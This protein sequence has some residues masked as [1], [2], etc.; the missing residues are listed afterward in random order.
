[1]GL[2]L[3]TTFSRESYGGFWEVLGPDNH[4]FTL[5][6][7]RDNF[8]TSL[9]KTDGKEMSLLVSDIIPF[10]D[11]WRTN[12][13]LGTNNSTQ[14]EDINSSSLWIVFHYTQPK[15]VGT[16]GNL[17]FFTIPSL[18]NATDGYPLVTELWK[19][20]GTPEGTTM[21]Y[22]D[23]GNSSR[24]AGGSFS[25]GYVD[26]YY[27]T[28]SMDFG[29]YLYFGTHSG[30]DTRLWR[31]D[32]TAIGTESVNMSTASTVVQPTN[33]KK[34]SEGLVFSTRTVN[35]NFGGYDLQLW[36]VND[37]FTPLSLSRPYWFGQ[38]N[39]N[40]GYWDLVEMGGWIYLMAP[41][42]NSDITWIAKSPSVFDMA[43]PGNGGYHSKSIMDN[44]YIFFNNQ[45]YIL[46]KKC[47]SHI[48]EEVSCS[49]G[50]PGQYSEIGEQ[51]FDAAYSIELWR[52]GV[53]GGDGDWQR[54][55]VSNIS[56]YIENNIWWLTTNYGNQF[57]YNFYSD[58]AQTT[59]FVG[60]ATPDGNSPLRYFFYADAD[61]L[62]GITSSPDE[63][64][65]HL[66]SHFSIR[67]SVQLTGQ[68]DRFVRTPLLM[69]NNVYQSRGYPSVL[70]RDQQQEG[71]HYA[72]NMDGTSVVVD[73]RI[74]LFAY[75][76]N[77]DEDRGLYNS[78]GI[79]RNFTG[80]V[81]GILLDKWDFDQ[82][83]VCNYEDQD[84]DGDGWDDSSDDF[85]RDPNENTDTDSD[86]IGDNADFDDD[87]D[88]YNDSVDEFP[89]NER[90][91]I[92]TDGD[93]IG[94]NSD[95]DDDGDGW[96]DWDEL[97]NCG[98][99]PLDN[100]SVPSDL[101]GDMI[102]N[103][104]DYDDDG[105]GF[106]DTSDVFPLDASE[107]LD[108]DEDGI[109]DN[110]DTDDD[111]DGFTD[112]IDIWPRDKCAALD[113]DSDG[114]PDSVIDDCQTNLTADDDDDGDSVLDV[115]DFCSPGET[116][117]ISGA[118]LGTDHDG[119][120]CRDDGEDTDDDN[121][122][123]NDS[124]DG[125]P[126]GITGAAFNAIFDTDGDGCLESEDSDD[127]NDG[128]SDINDDFPLDPSE[129]TDTDGDGIGDNADTDDD[130]DGWSDHEETYECDTNPLD[131]NSIPTD[132]DNDLECDKSDTDD[133]NDG[134][135]DIEELLIGTD[136][137]SEDSD[138][139][140]VRDSEDIFPLDSTE[141]VDTDGD[142]TGDN[143]DAFPSI[144][145]YQTYGGIA[146]ELSAVLIIVIIA[147]LVLRMRG[148]GESEEDSPEPNNTDPMEDY[149]QQLIA[150][151]DPEETARQYAQQHAE[152]FQK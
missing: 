102:C 75:G 43:G 58:P 71:Y 42:V 124:E 151:G 26:D 101:D 31:T 47:Y 60:W 35:L 46:E 53:Q 14:I 73:G 112:E 64:T 122:G 49:S 83:G 148:G 85:P 105:D 118:T 98:T 81:Y 134:L 5:M 1:M 77:S 147:L 87:G 106:N 51:I 149:V 11:S 18:L 99:D 41:T 119:D 21:F 2:E 33:F 48:G 34:T 140:G 109:G 82:D 29:N 45:L 131:E 120:G 44:G 108:N 141:W 150:Q 143:S 130:G 68:N 100:Y 22:S 27:G 125:C 103:E 25:R 61:D 88:G 79:L 146:L 76:W 94:D 89:L 86:G 50:W 132:T 70:G 16:L 115:D 91:W 24:T 52:Y 93:G 17:V 62:N 97:N 142:G 107:W 84:D 104:V 28:M 144:A 123:V 13:Y 12:E 56:L 139:D 136:P 117:W 80:E 114:M 90:E 152:H 128:V 54:E 39:P 95:S 74:L 126:R 127:D 65:S 9:W 57:A 72:S 20:D 38:N 23:E 6:A 145:R 110:S 78:P 37:S 92:D 129:T 3:N 55:Y 59:L 116:G 96:Y 10:P 66:W 32:G 19:T 15:V 133:D 69:A 63:D 30:S 8:S 40:P 138:S 137:L 67:N 113:T 7:T 111:N 36:L 135:L 121:D 4:D